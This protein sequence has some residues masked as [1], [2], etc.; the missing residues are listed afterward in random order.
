MNV[1]ELELEQEEPICMKQRLKEI[2]WKRYEN[3][4]ELHES[5]YAI[6]IVLALKLRKIPCY[7]LITVV[8]ATLE[9]DI[10]M[11]RPLQRKG[12]QRLLWRV[13]MAFPSCSNKL[14][15]KYSDSSSQ[16][17]NSDATRAKYPEKS[18]HFLEQESYF[19]D[20]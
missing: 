14:F 4:S 15:W 1:V 9:N 16:F 12:N 19:Q 20:L 10:M 7:K 18:L 8:S 6:C 2:V 11:G 17:T 13:I 5:T 3:L